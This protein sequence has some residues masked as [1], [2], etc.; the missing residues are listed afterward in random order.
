MTV[1]A[2]LLYLTPNPFISHCTYVKALN[3][4]LQ[5]NSNQGL[6]TKKT[7]LL[8]SLT[9]QCRYQYLLEEQG[10]YPDLYN[11]ASNPKISQ[12]CLELSVPF[13]NF[14]FREMKTR[15]PTQLIFFLQF[16]EG[17]IQYK[18]LI[19]FK[20]EE[21]QEQIFHEDELSFLWLIIFSYCSE[22]LYILDLN[23]K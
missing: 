21:Q 13:L 9:V 15:M 22:L 2:D 5:N 12:N 17:L 3:S 18:E 7:W 1:Q 16:V 8:A 11:Q 14:L 23:T 19:S 10:S 4:L 20:C 6:N